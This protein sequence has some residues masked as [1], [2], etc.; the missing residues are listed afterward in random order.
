MWSKRKRRVLWLRFLRR[1][2]RINGL[3][4]NKENLSNEQRMGIRIFERAVTIKDVDIF[5]SP[6]SDSIY[7]EINDI[8]LI[9]DGN[10]LQIINGKYQ[11]DL[12]Y[13]EQVR[14]RMRDKVLQVIESKKA[15][16]E[17]RIRAKS[18]RTLHSI[19]E[20]ITILRDSEA[21]E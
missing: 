2:G 19:L 4:F 12:H 21:K 6:L 14:S 13:N 15:A 9:L 20:D 8:Y 10:D 18:D 5:M 17:Q 11:Y 7:I 16:V 3:V 1:L